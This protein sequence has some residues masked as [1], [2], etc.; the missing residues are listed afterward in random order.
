M[1]SSDNIQKGNKADK[2]NILDNENIRDLFS[3]LKSAKN[4]KQAIELLLKAAEDGKIEQISGNNFKNGNYYVLDLFKFDAVPYAARMKKIS[5]MNLGIAPKQVGVISKDNVYFIISKIDGCESG[6]L[7]PFLQHK[8][9]VP[10]ENLLAAYK[11]F[12][13]LTKA[14]LVDKSVAR[15]IGQWF[16]TP[17]DNKV[18]IPVWNELAPIDNNLER[19]KLMERYHNMLFGK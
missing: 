2:G 7:L 14:G 1:H 19:M 16:I 12:Q 4:D 8:D 15:S 17:D 6:D 3:D 9:R 13:K 10:K 11:D 5:D 18:V